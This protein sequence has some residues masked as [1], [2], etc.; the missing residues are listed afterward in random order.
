MTRGWWWRTSRLIRSFLFTYFLVTG[1][2]EAFFQSPC[3]ACGATAVN[4]RAS[5]R[6]TIGLVTLFQRD[7]T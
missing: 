6:C 7:I 3:A 4:D 2:L 1:F 5:L